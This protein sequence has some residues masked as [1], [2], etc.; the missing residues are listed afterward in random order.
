MKSK[1]CRLKSAR[2]NKRSMRLKGMSA[3]LLAMFALSEVAG[4]DHAAI[5]FTVLSTAHAATHDAGVPSLTPVISNPQAVAN[6]PVVPLRWG[7]GVMQE[8]QRP[9]TVPVKTRRRTIRSK[10]I[11]APAIQA[12]N[13]INTAW[14]AYQA[15]HYD[16]AQLRYS[17]VMDG[18]HNVDVQLGLASIALQRHH[19]E[20]ALQHYHQALLLDPHNV[21]A[22]AALATWGD[23]AYADGLEAQIKQ[24]LV[25]QPSARL[26]CSLGDLYAGQQRWR[27]AEAAYFASYQADNEHADYAYNLAVS[28][29]HLRQYEAALTY[30]LRA[31]NLVLADGGRRDISL[32][33]QRIQ[34]LQDAGRPSP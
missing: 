1:Q 12:V 30:Y 13:L 25:Q 34:Q 18:E 4:Y 15:G 22:L 16:L 11:A 3:G 9:P 14:Q 32:L 8:I 23:V 24:A 10:P 5:V 27:E 31:R 17:Q 21:V 20:L 19:K 6:K 26:Q 28:L 33:N 2:V 7:D 29:D